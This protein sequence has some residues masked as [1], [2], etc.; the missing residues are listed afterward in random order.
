ML[1]S[2]FTEKIS[3]GLPLSRGSVESGSIPRPALLP[4]T[5]IDRLSPNNLGRVA[6]GCYEG[7]VREIGG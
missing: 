2:A 1:S 6:E 4:R 5:A 7:R 3:E